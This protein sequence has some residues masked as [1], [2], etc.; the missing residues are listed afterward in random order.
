MGDPAQGK[1]RLA[2]QSGAKS[3]GSTEQAVPTLGTRSQKP[4][5]KE[6]IW[7]LMAVVMRW[8]ATRLTYSRLFSSVTL[9]LVKP[10]VRICLAFQKRCHKQT[11]RHSAWILVVWKQARKHHRGFVQST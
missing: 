3:S 11:K 10:T 8:R 9:Q 2:L 6:L 7:G 4:S 5:R 1:L